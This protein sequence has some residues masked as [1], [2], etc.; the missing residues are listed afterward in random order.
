VPILRCPG[1]TV[2]SSGSRLAPQASDF[3]KLR[4]R[5]LAAQP[6]RLRQEQAASC[7][8]WSNWPMASRAPSWEILARAVLKTGIS[9]QRLNHLFSLRCVSAAMLIC[10]L[11]GPHWPDLHPATYPTAASDRGGLCLELLL[12]LEGFEMREGDAGTL[13]PIR[14]PP[15]APADFAHHQHGWFQASRVSALP[16]T[17]HEWA[18]PSTEQGLPVRHQWF[19][20]ALGV[21]LSMSSRE[22]RACSD[23]R[24]ARSEASSVP[25]RRTIAFAQAPEPARIRCSRPQ[26]RPA[27]G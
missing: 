14:F 3:S 21:P 19:A 6:D 20:W 24:G 1:P 12:G 7:T 23:C 11:C 25:P 22:P 26:T 13:S 4:L 16:G 18:I 27:P 5:A 17:A 15:S 2:Y 10:A 9:K 8:V